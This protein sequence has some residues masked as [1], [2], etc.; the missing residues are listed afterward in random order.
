MHVRNGFGHENAV[1]DAVRSCDEHRPQ[2]IS[3]RFKLRD[4]D[5]SSFSVIQA[6][7]GETGDGTA[8][9]GVVVGTVG[10]V[11][12]GDEFCAVPETKLTAVNP[13]NTPSASPPEM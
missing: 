4:D 3:E 8:T 2:L 1:L 6:T 11:A 5:W 10:T 7:G 12:V 13:A 9:T